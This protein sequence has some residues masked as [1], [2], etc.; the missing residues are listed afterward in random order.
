MAWA[1]NA[2]TMNASQRAGR[3]LGRDRHGES[4][5]H[6]QQGGSQ[7]QSSYAAPDCARLRHVARNASVAEHFERVEEAIKQLA[8]DLRD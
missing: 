6:D 4:P 1:R 8:V 2:V 5:L 7:V 3:K